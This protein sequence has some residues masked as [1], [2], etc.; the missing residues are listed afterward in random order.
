MR[1]NGE[2]DQQEDKIVKTIEGHCFNLLPGLDAKISRYYNIQHQFAELGQVSQK[3]FGRQG[4]LSHTDFDDRLYTPIKNALPADLCQGIVKRLEQDKNGLADP[5]LINRLLP[6]ILNSTTDS[7]LCSYFASE[8]GL[9]SYVYS[10]V[11][12]DSA[13]EH[14][15]C[16]EGPSKQLKIRIYLNGSDDH[17]CRVKLADRS[18]TQQLKKA[19]IVFVESEENPKDI[20]PLCQVEGITLNETVFDQFAAGDGL[21]FNPNLLAHTWENPHRTNCHFL[22]LCFIPSPYHWKFTKD[23]VLPVQ[24]GAPDFVGKA[25]DILSYVALKPEQDR[26]I[27]QFPQENKITS[28]TQLRMILRDIFGDSDFADT[29]FARLIALDPEL[30]Q[31]GSLDDLVQVLRQSFRDS[32]D[33]TG[34]LGIDNVNNLTCL[35]KFSADFKVSVNRY[36]GKDIPDPKAVFWPAPNDERKYPSRFS[37]LPFVQKYPIL[38]FDTPIGSAGSCFAQEIAKVFQEENYNY[39]VTERNDDPNNGIMVDNYECGDKYAIACANYGILFNTP[40]FRQLAERAFGVKPTKK[41]LFQSNEGYWVDPYREN[42]V[43]TSKQA[44]A[45]DYQLHLDATRKALE[46]SKVFIITLGLNECWQFRDGS[47]LSRNPHHN[48]YPFVQPKVLSVQENVDNIQAFFDIVKQH[49][50][51]L[52]LIISVSPVPFLATGRAK[53]HHIVTANMHS[54]AVLLVAAEMLVKNNEDMYYLP[55]YELVTQC[56]KEPWAEDDRH[57]SRETVGQVVNMFKE[58]FTK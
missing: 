24:F 15:R 11:E 57:V 27:V 54:K 32:I 7:L 28:A 56:L 20:T 22:E 40:S 52:K 14:W 18:S 45:D 25:Q 23:S 2:R 41:L 33:W 1:F 50:P 44:Y 55:S 39:V 4:I 36:F 13:S 16:D 51:D 30:A 38:D 49:N 21:L 53:E 6:F 9:L 12:S 5:A 10:S 26:E 17:Q 46:Q 35:A 37:L 3:R 48:M 8:Y 29:M 34:D 31:L 43:F 58:I 19:G 47:V 42:V